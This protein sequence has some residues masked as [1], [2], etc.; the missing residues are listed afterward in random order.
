M[1][2]IYNLNI[3]ASFDGTFA[4]AL[5]VPAGWTA[6]VGDVPNVFG[7][8]G[9]GAVE[10]QM[11]SSYA[12]DTQA[13]P[14]EVRMP[15]MIY[16]IK[17]QSIGPVPRGASTQINSNMYQYDSFPDCFIIY[18]HKRMANQIASDADV[19]LPFDEGFSI[20]ING[21]NSLLNG[22]TQAQNYQICKKYVRQDFNEFRGYVNAVIG[23]TSQT[24]ATSGGILVLKPA[25]DLAIN[26]AAIAP[27]MVGYRIQMQ[28]NNLAVHNYTGA[29]FVDGDLELV[30]ISVRSGELSLTPSSGSQSSSILNQADVVAAMSKEPMYTG[31]VAMLEGEQT[32]G[33]SGGKMKLSSV[34]SRRRYGGAPS[35]GAKSAGMIPVGVAVPRTHTARF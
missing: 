6:N 19:F 34:S 26:E 16:D 15:N 10:L 18:C 22:N 30:V 9:S 2:N 5:S 11:M 14:P 21:N 13:I 23:G 3:N 25:I 35:G 32:G 8:S 31:E 1:A 4:K 20:T 28:F 17:S 33:R 12:P 29:P 27:N 24:V 7:T